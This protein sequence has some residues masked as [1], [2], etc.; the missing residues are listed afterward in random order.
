M[1]DGNVPT[2]TRL[3]TDASSLGVCRVGATGAD[4]M[5]RPSPRSRRPRV[6]LSVTR[7]RQARSRPGSMPTPSAVARTA[8]SVPGQP[9]RCRCTLANDPARRPQAG[10]RR[11]PA[12]RARRCSRPS[13]T[14][15][16]HHGQHHV[17]VRGV[18]ARRCAHQ[19]S[20]PTPRRAGGGHWQAVGL[21]SPSI[22]SAVSGLTDVI[23]TG[24]PGSSPDCPTRRRSGRPGWSFESPQPTVG[25][26]L[27]V[28]AGLDDRLPLWGG[29][30][31]PTPSVR[32]RRLRARGVVRGG[33][34]RGLTSQSH[35]SSR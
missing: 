9:M 6:D 3:L 2:G 14:S 18:G 16:V 32:R 1:I 24:M 5:C 28:P 7:V 25:P 22:A 13:C 34:P 12:G 27:G 17:E 35:R 29:W 8:T 23:R 30:S 4:P 31:R 26:P 33:R 10:R 19:C 15:A 21:R 11:T 20:W